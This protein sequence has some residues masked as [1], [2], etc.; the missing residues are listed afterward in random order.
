MITS[1]QVRAARALLRWT[2][3]KLA[4]KALVALTALKRLESDRH[5][6]PAVTPS[7]GGPAGAA[8]ASDPQQ[9][10]AV[11][12][13]AARIEPRREGYFNAV[14]VYSFSPG[15]LYRI[16]ASPGKL[17]TSRSNTASSSPARGRSRPATRRAGSS[18]TRPAARAKPGGSMCS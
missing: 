12:N 2:Q 5:R 4:D 6:P 16:Y 18:A 1:R 13:R 11:A 3:E 17:P 8:E 7:R 10:V 9:R 15:A 14:Q